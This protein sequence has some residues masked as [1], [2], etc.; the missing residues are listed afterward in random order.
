M[1]RLASSL[2]DRMF[3]VT[4]TFLVENHILFNLP[5]SCNIEFGNVESIT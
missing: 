5:K 3:N 1:A 4:N 2:F